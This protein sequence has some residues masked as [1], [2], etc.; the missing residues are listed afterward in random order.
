MSDG[1]LDAVLT[2]LGKVPACDR[3][4]LDAI[5]VGVTHNRLVVRNA[6]EKIVKASELPQPRTEN[7]RLA[8]LA[9]EERRRRELLT[10]D[11]DYVNPRRAETE[12]FILEV[13]GGR[14]A[15]PWPGAT[16]PAAGA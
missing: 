1:E 9:A 12:K 14:A 16:R 2:R 4:A 11:A 8:E 6:A 10:P 5:R 13:V 15:T 7:E 3:A